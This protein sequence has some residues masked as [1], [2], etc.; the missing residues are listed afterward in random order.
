M[1]EQLKRSADTLAPVRKKV[2]RHAT[3]LASD[4]ARSR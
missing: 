2:L 1:Q 3:L 4:D